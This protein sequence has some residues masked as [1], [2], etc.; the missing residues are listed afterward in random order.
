MI[1]IK[2][3]LGDCDRQ[4]TFAAIVRALDQTFANQSAHGILDVDLMRKINMRRRTDFFAVANF[5]KLR[6]AK[7]ADV[8]GSV[9]AGVTDPGY[10]SDVDYC[11]AGVFNALDL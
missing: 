6:A 9:S 2:A 8:V 11:V 4:S 5:Q 3:A 7:V 10:S 1:R